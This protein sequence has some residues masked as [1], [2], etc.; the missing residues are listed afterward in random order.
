MG[1]LISQGVKMAIEEINAAGGIAGS[2]A[3]LLLEDTATEAKT[4][5][6]AFKKLVEVDGVQV[7][8]GPMISPAV[9]AIGPYAS[10]RGVVFISPS[11]TAPIVAEQP[12][13]L[14]QR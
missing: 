11:S 4:A 1:H 12:W 9:M 14:S 6:E 8:I 13:A 10:E 3:K 5:L 2:P 7:V